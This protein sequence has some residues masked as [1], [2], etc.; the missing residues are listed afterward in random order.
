MITL[1][2]DMEVGILE[3]D[4]QHMELVD[5]LNSLVSMGHEAVSKE[6]TQNTLDMLEEYIVKHFADEEELQRKNNYPEYESH[7]K[8]HQLYIAEFQKLKKEF[9][10]NGHSIKFTMDLNNSIINWIVKHIKSA[11]V[12]LGKF[13]KNKGENS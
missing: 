11:D 4:T 6:E 8:L 2:K 3:I 5:R 10:A 7:R 1:S 9:D 12:E 13:L